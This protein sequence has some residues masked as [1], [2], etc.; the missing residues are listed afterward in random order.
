MPP[1]RAVAGYGEFVNDAALT[2]RELQFML[3][4]IDGNGPKSKEKIIF[5]FEQ[6]KT[7]DNERIKGDFDRWQLGKPDLLKTLAPTA[8]AA[9]QGD[10]MREIEIDLGQRSERWIRG[11]EFKPGDRRVVRAATFRVRETGQW[12]GSWTPWYGMT[13][14]P[15]GVAYRV[16]AGAHVTAEVQYRSA[17]EPVEERGQLGIYFSAKPADRIA[18]DMEVTS[19]PMAGHGGAKSGMTRFG[20]SVRLDA[21]ALVLALNPEVPPGVK[22]FAVNARQPN[23]VVTPLLLV[24]DVLPEWPTPYLLKTPLRFPAGT[25]LSVSHEF[26]AQA[27]GGPPPEHIKLTLSIVA[28]GPANTT[29]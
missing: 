6:M 2:S 17:N 21:P 9:G 10:T 18:T 16:P 13:A 25:E 5:N 4:W 26:D 24:R 20:G 22:S 3:A 1:W 14:L 12:L 23:G 28:G 19:V 27:S 8:V 29:N 15:D 7:P 11:L